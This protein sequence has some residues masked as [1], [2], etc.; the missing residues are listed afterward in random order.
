MKPIPFRNECPL[1]ELDRKQIWSGSLKTFPVPQG[2]LPTGLQY[3]TLGSTKSL[4]FSEEK[5]SNTCILSS[6]H[7]KTPRRSSNH[8][9]F[10]FPPLSHFRKW[11]AFLPGCRNRAADSDQM[12]PDTLAVSGICYPLRGLTWRTGTTGWGCKCNLLENFHIQ[13]EVTSKA[14]NSFR[15]TYLRRKW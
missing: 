15:F 10:P 7:N 1:R 5:S 12:M 8:I 3:I 11:Y 13:G 2:H 6:L 4:A 9:S 14:A